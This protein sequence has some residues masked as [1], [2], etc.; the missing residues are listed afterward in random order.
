MDEDERVE[1]II[2][3]YR[4]GADNYRR[5]G[6]DV[7]RMLKD[8]LTAAEIPVSSVTHR[9]KDAESLQRKLLSSKKYETLGDITDIVGARVITYFSDD[10]D[11]VANI[12]RR[13]DNFAVDF[14][15]SVDKRRE[16]RPDQ[17]GYQSLHL[18]VT[19][20]QQRIFTENRSL[21][22]MKIEIQVRSLLQH[23]WA[24]IEHAY[25]KSER[26][27]PPTIARRVSLVAGLLEIGD[28]EFV[29]IR[30]DAAE[31]AQS[32]PSSTSQ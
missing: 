17:F 27:L 18:V 12:I 29:A 32:L 6:E 16:L 11:S 4:S 19:L 7:E 22:G 14:T 9:L 21:Q 20:S 30:E 24:E 1:S 10:V 8:L 3:A 25:Y 2:V 5:L 28:N 26:S 13:V 23:A 31:I 15:N